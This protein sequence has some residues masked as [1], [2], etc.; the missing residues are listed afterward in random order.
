MDLRELLT[1]AKKNGAS[2]IHLISNHVPTLRINGDIVPL[3]VSAISTDEVSAMIGDLMSEEQKRQY[4]EELEID[5]AV[6]VKGIGRYRLN[7]FTSING[8][9]AVMRD[10]P[11][12]V[13]SIEEL[14]LPR[15]IER[16]SLLSK[17]LVLVTGPTGSGKSTTLAAM[18]DHINQYRKRH[19]LTIEDPIEFIHKSNLS[20]VNQR[21]LGVHTRSFSSALKSALREDPDVIL[22][23]ELRDIETISLALT[24]AETGHL[25]LATL[26]TSSANKTI[27]RII[28]VF[29]G[30]DKPMVRSMLSSSLEGIV[31][32]ILI[33]TADESGRVAAHEILS[34]NSAI[35][36][37]I[38]DNKI[39]QIYSMM[40]V[41]TKH[42]MKV[43]KDSIY[44]LLDEGIITEENAR[45]ALNYNEEEL[46]DE[47]GSGNF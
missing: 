33:R 12:A 34:V 27:D 28:D 21:E 4:R 5:F 20:I 11:T 17:G 10:I 39:P 8:P 9:A 37:L 31:S 45:A 32:Q 29:P 23:G 42:G 16:F 30:D 19:I 35:R 38:R 47:Q 15:I 7:A 3:R 2:D 43:M 6:S 41:G 25:V 18:V 44:E 1:F 24:A 26:H 13:K 36:N 40:Q 22:I 46:E 14:K